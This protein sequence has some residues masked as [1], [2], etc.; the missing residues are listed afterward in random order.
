MKTRSLLT[1]VLLIVAAL[2]V[3]FYTFTFTVDQDEL[4]IRLS[5]DGSAPQ[6]DFKPGLQFKWPLVDRVYKFDKRIVSHD[7]AEDRFMTSEGQLLRADY[8]VKWQ[9]ADAAAYYKATSG[10]E[11]MVAE[12]LGESVKN[13]V[14]EMIARRSLQQAV[15]ADRD[16]YHAEL[17]SVVAKEATPL[18]V[19]LVDVRIRRISLPESYNESVFTGMRQSFTRNAAQIK[20]NGEASA[21]EIM[22]EA[23]RKRVELIADANRDAAI[24]KGEGDA[25]AASIYASAYARNTE[26]YAFYRSLQAYRTAIG[27]PGDVLV[28]SPDSEFFKYL[29]KPAAR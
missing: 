29:N 21:Q 20:A 11:N 8:F 15:S 4:A 26:F 22:A 13:A 2:A 27:K 12:R 16:V 7:Y 28:V 10:D 6:T 17:F 24:T 18:G 1:V 3:M 19:K 9:I 14:K 23:D 25:K 5:T